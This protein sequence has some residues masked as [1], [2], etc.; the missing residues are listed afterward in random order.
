VFVDAGTI[1]A[2]AFPRRVITISSPDA[3][4]SSIWPNRLFASKAPTARITPP[5]IAMPGS[6]P[7]ETRTVE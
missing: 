6:L 7:D 5:T 4:W 2:T 3:T 1:R